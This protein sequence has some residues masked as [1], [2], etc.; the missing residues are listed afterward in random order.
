M[1]VPDGCRVEGRNTV[2][3][4]SPPFSL[5]GMVCCEPSIVAMASARSTRSS[6]VAF[7]PS[8]DDRPV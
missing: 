6:L 4:V 5:T 7:A 3:P 1:A 8:P 2:A